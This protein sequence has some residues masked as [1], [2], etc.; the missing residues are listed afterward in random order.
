MK[1]FSNRIGSCGERIQSAAE[2]R[3]Q[4]DRSIGNKH[5]G[6]VAD[7]EAPLGGTQGEDR[8]NAFPSITHGCSGAGLFWIAAMV[9]PCCGSRSRIFERGTMA[10]RW[11]AETLKSSARRRSALSDDLL[12]SAALRNRAAQPCCRLSRPQHS[13]GAER[14]RTPFVSRR[15]AVLDNI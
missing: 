13:Q 10:D 3:A 12:D 8:T 15:A 7:F 5:G 14:R 4:R 2:A 1:A 11:N 6:S 9:V